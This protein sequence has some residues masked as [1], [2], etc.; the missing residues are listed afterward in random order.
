MGRDRDVGAF[1]EAALDELDVRAIHVLLVRV[2]DRRGLE[3]RALH[4]PE[5]RLRREQALEVVGSAVQ[6]RLQHRAHAVVPCRTEPLV[7][8]QCRV[9][10]VGLLHVDAEERAELTGSRDEPFDVLVRD[11]LVER[12]PEVREL[13][14]D[15]GLEVLGDEPLENPLVLVRDGGGT[16]CVGNRL[17]K[18]RRVRMEPRVV[19]PAQHRDA[20][21][22]RL[23]RDEA[24]RADA[25]PVLLY[26]PLEALAV[27]RVEDRRPR[28]GRESCSDAGHA[29]ARLPRRIDVVIQVEDVRGVV[30]S[31]DL[32]E[33]VVVRAVCR[34]NRIRRLV[35]AR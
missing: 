3:V 22:E 19:Q 7:D 27:R 28:Q 17:A 14:R 8:A 33:P 18:Q 16:G 34:A 23:A 5:V 13:Q 6:V 9:D 10:E 35:V 26:E 11:I 1:A 30:L 21:V 24:R 20:L 29:G 15:V 4:D 2:C 25:P 31:L 12:Q 32:D